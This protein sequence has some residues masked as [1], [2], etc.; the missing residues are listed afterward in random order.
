METFNSSNKTIKKNENT[1]SIYNLIEN[2]NSQ[3]GKILNN[4]VKI[5]QINQN[6]EEKNI[7]NDKK[8]T[9]NII[10]NN[11]TYNTN[12]F[13]NSKIKL[14]IFDDNSKFYLKEI[15]PF[16]S[17]K[18]NNS[19]DFLNQF[20]NLKTENKILYLSSQLENNIWFRGKIKKI[21]LINNKTV[22]QYYEDKYNI[23][24]MS[25]LKKGRK[26]YK[27]FSDQN[28]FNKIGSMS[29]NFIGNIFNI[30]MDNNEQNKCQIKYV[31]ILILLYR[32]LIFLV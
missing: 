31:K 1:S 5:F 12:N 13:K 17:I 22:F 6:K 2:N 25:A 28:L 23:F 10:S 26:S 29:I 20:L 4:T 14:K 9:L 19:D 27:I 3:I 7:E 24:L 8:E 32:I 18:R 15:L 16:P 30:K 11:N 21:K